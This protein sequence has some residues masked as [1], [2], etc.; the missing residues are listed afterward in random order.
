M[1]EEG[2]KI[3]VAIVDD[4]EVVR[5]GLRSMIERQP[6]MEFVGEA[7]T[8]QEALRLIP[9]RTDVAILDIR[10]PDQSGIE[11][12]RQVKA[13]DPDVSVIMLTSFGD[14]DVLF[15][16]LLA[17]AAGYLLKE[18]RGRAVIDA[19][20]TVASGGSLLDP[21][22]AE[23]VLSRI[24][25]A[26]VNAKENPLDTLTSQERRILELIAEGKTNKEIG[27][28]VFLSDKT[29]KHYVSN[30][31]SKLGLSRRSEAAAFLARHEKA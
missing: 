22:V 18:T 5:V 31:L 3:R 2:K 11:V 15:Q 28:I 10:L 6:D 4:H 27:E 16:S 8:A 17:G 30:I 29:V 21:G 25:H 23:K 14:D 7:A 19:I 26:N 13:E 20:R 9:G 1:S 12:C 24:R